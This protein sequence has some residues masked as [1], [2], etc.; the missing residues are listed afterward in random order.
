MEEMSFQEIK[1]DVGKEI[2]LSLSKIDEKEVEDFINLILSHKKIFV[3]GVGRVM[4]MLQAFAK[5]LK[6]LGLDSYV[7]GETTVPAIGEKDILIAA[8]GSGETLTTVNTAKL[9]QNQ[10]AKVALITSSSHSTL[11]ELADASVRIP[12]PTKLHLSEEISSKQPMT[13][14]FEQCLLIFSDCISM[15]IEKKLNISEEKMWKVHANLE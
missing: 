13:T 7:V 8:S 1:S 5:R 3:I 6:H 4:L 11:K 14:L 12:S 15:I 9:A 2:E 10:G